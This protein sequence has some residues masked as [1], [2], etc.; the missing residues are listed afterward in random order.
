MKFTIFTG[1]TTVAKGYDI[2]NNELI[3]I[4]A[5]NFYQG[6]FETITISPVEL[7]TVLKNLKQGQFLTAG[8][9]KTLNVG[10][11]P[12]D[13]SRTTE[14][15]VFPDGE[16]LLIID[17]D[18][19]QELGID[20]VDDFVSK[21]KSLDKALEDV[22]LVCS[23]SASSNII[24]NANDSGLRGIHSFMAVDNARAIP[25]ILDTLHKRAV[26]AGFGRAQVTANGRVL[27][28]SLVDLA[29]KSSNQP[30]YEGGAR[31]LNRNIT[32]QRD[33]A[34]Y[35]GGILI[36]SAL[37]PIT[38]ADA[39]AFLNICNSLKNSVQEQADST[40]TAWT[41]KRVDEMVAKG[42]TESNAEHLIKCVFDGGDL[43]GEIIIHTDR[44]GE[45]SVDEILANPAKYH[46]Q[47]CADPLDPE[48]GQNKAKIYSKQDKPCINSMAHGGGTRYYLQRNMF[49][50]LSLK[51]S[52]SGSLDNLFKDLVLKEEHVNKM[53]DAEFLIP[54]MIVRGHVAAYIAPGN[55][56]K[57]SIF[58]FLSELLAAKGLKVLYINVDGSPSDLKRHHAHASL[59][60]YQVIAP[61]AV[62]GKSAQDVI[63]NL[64]AIIENN[65]CCDDYVFIL[66]TLKKF[67]DVIDKRQSKELYKLMRA[68]T[69]KGAT[70]CLLGHCNKY[71]DAEG[72]LV[73]EGTADL[74][75]DLDEL[76]YLNSSKN[77]NKKILEITTYPDK[78]RAEF[79]PISFVID[80]NENRKVTMSE[81]VLKILPPEE[82]E[83]VDAIK[84]AIANGLSG[85]TE[86]IEWVKD[87]ITAGDKKIRQRL[88]RYSKGDNPIFESKSTGFGKGLCYS[89]HL[90]FEDLG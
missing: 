33:I 3:K 68:L 19:L 34:T 85:Q 60:N 36:S 43:Y 73:Y 44:F 13:A 29:M 17:G 58:I 77:I 45:V 61:D 47:T 75:N 69:V 74:R 80:F 32:Q 78:V 76:I 27:I 21:I 84:D 70:I 22:E 4:D 2:K 59:H 7:S 87:K 15:F 48:Y 23:P 26:I 52:T 46:E 51:T 50:D 83:I 66:D 57:T 31:L 28:K 62:D 35:A 5:G 79:S 55:G 53:A 56:G 67:T 89:I 90:P 24:F 42:L 63:N 16:G 8:V 71:K 86:I 1:K 25:E 9:H 88:L 30:C 38:D 20:T 64:K 40:R 14:E 11:C 39:S 18:S 6:S 41:T 72:A 82:Q 37:A 12:K 10:Q 49:E 54:N 65:L 81:E